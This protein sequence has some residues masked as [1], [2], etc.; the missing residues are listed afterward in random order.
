MKPRSV[1]SLAPRLIGAIAI[2]ATVILGTAGC[3]MVSTQAT[4]IGY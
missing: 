1:A 3:S 2:G 4:T